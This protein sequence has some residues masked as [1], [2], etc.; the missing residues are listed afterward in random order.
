MKI[1]EEP[2][3]DNGWKCPICGTNEKK[4]VTLI[5]IAGTEKDGMCE[6]RQYH[7]S[8]IDLVEISD[9]KVYKLRVI[10]HQYY[11]EGD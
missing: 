10:I 5:K 1:F 3:L 6:A 7:V 8:C 11:V 4:P 2:N 9:K